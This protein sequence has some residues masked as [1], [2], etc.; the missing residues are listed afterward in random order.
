MN[1][2]PEGLSG[3]ASRLLSYRLKPRV[4]EIL[5]AGSSG[6]TKKFVHNVCFLAN[7]LPQFSALLSKLLTFCS[8]PPLL[9]FSVQS[10]VLISVYLAAIV[11]ILLVPVAFT[12]YPVISFVKVSH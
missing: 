8:S 12:L 10:L 7:L 6:K 11:L 1:V 5:Q 9:V 2:L 3:N 4:A